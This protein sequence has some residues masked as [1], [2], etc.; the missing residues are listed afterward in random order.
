MSDAWN[1]QVRFF[2]DAG[3]ERWSLGGPG[4]SPGQMIYPTGVCV[5]RSRNVFVVDSGNHRVQK[6]DAHGRVL[7]VAGSAGTADGQFGRSSPD[8]TRPY[9]VHR[10]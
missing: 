1:H 10:S 2:D 9:T 4:R 6:F 8:L 5:E 7:A 3:R